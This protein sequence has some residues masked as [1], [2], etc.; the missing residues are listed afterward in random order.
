MAAI[1]DLANTMTQTL[2]TLNQNV[3]TAV[4]AIQSGGV[5]PTTLQA[6]QN[7]SDGMKSANNQLASVVGGPTV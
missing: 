3:A 1:D 7:V 4:G 6:L 5:N 2:A